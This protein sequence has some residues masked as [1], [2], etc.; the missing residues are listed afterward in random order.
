M[1]VPDL[2]SEV[3]W[4]D[5]DPEDYSWASDAACRQYLPDFPVNIWT[6]PQTT[7]ERRIAMRVCW[8]ECKVR[9]QCLSEGLLPVWQPIGIFGGRNANQRRLLKIHWRKTGL[10]PDEPDPI[11][12]DDEFCEYD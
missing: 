12:L 11:D 10:I 9:E 2:E 3:P 6:D 7:D 1:C 5:F 8:L 4:P